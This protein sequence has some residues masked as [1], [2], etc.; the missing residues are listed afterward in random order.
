MEKTTVILADDDD[1]SRLLLSKFIEALADFEVIGEASN[2]AELVD[3]VMKKQPDIALVDIHMPTLNGVEAVRVCQ[4]VNSHLQV[5]FT[6][7]SVDFAVDA[8]N[9]SAIDYIVKPIERI[10]LY[11]ALEKA[12]KAIQ[13][14]NN[15]NKEALNKIAIKSNNS[16]IYLSI[17]DIFFIEKE[18]RKCIIHTTNN[19]FETTQSLQELEEQLPFYFYKSHRSYLINIRKVEKIAPFGET[20][21][22]YFD[23]EKKVAHISKL[24]INDVYQLLGN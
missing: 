24:K 23:S 14:E 8:F 4:E 20:F 13:L 3:I 18:G 6:T 7:G 5:I 15:L 16:F 17:E 1:S 11:M 21:L 22:A 2:G 9:V 19:Q 12:K 10:R